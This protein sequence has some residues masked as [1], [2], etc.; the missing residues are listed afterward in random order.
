VSPWAKLIRSKLVRLPLRVLAAVSALGLLSIVTLWTAIIYDE[1]ADREAALNQAG[2]QT[3]SMAIALREHVHSVILSVDLILQALDSDYAGASGAYAMPK[4]I[5]QLPGLRESWLQV[6]I[7]GSNG[8]PVVTT[9][10]ADPG[11]TDLTDREHF[12]V[13]RDPAAR[14]PFISKPVVGRITGKP[15]MQITRRIERADGSFAG[16]SV[17]SLDPAYFARFFESIDLGPRGIIYLTGRDGIMRA[18]TTRSRDPYLGVGQD[19]TG[20]PVLKKLLAAPQ[21]IYRA[22]STIDGIERIYGFAADGEYPVIVAAG[23]AVDDILAEH[24]SSTI[25]EVAVGTVLSLVILGLVYRSMR[26]LSLRIRRDERLRRAQQ[27]ETVGQLSAG[28]AHDFNNILTV[29]VGNIERALKAAS[30]RD[31]RAHLGNVAD[32]ARRAQRVVANLL[33][34]SRQQELQ[35]HASDINGMVRTVA[36]LL[37]GGLGGKWTIRCEL[38]QYLPPVMADSVQIETA[39]LNLAMNARDAMPAGGTIAFETRLVENGET[40]LPNDLAAGRYVAVGVKDTGTGMTAEVL[41]KAFEPFFTTKEQGTG[42][43][44]SQVFGVAKQLGGT[45]TIDSS[46]RGGTAVTIYLPTMPSED[47]PIDAET[48]SIEPRL[49]KPEA[50]TSNAMIL[51]ADDE[52]QVCEFICSILS[53]AG[54]APIEVHDGPAALRALE[55]SP[56]RLAVLDIAMPGMSGI[57]V[58]EQARRHGWDGDV[59]FVSG[60]TDSASLARIHDKPFLAKPFG[61]QALRDRV[62]QILAEPDKSLL[63]SQS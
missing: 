27:L 46:E 24:R 1:H 7:I 23:M 13:H 58:Y 49:T 3:L 42:L 31:R 20:T 60:F 29:I 38:A 59:L 30:D 35:P 11:R 22:H 14:Q 25:I 43:G 2:T 8:Y 18:R 9:A 10:S 48:E 47:A 19:F 40:G 28:V 56:V 62:A 15:S 51:V 6:G 61:V 53:E 45:V 26:E 4:W 55:A 32:A 39:L 34:F 17:V 5:T 63:A 50:S 52:P 33:A 41:A 57:E 12:L 16:V 37:S 36:D 44:L 54:Y 21:G